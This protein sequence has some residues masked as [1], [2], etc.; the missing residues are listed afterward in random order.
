MRY[1]CGTC[2]A[3]AEIDKGTKTMIIEYKAPKVVKLRRSLGF[4][5]PSHLDCEFTKTID[6]IDLEQLDPVEESH[7]FAFER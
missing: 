1:R 2:G 5:R 4:A 3:V 6:D 7:L